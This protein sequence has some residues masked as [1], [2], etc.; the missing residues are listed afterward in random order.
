MT[1]S[2]KTLLIG[3]LVSVSLIVLAYFVEK[4]QQ[5]ELAALVEKCGQ[6]NHSDSPDGPWKQWEKAPLV[7]E[8]SDLILNYNLVG[9]QKDI[10]EQFYSSSNTV[11][12]FK[13][14]AGSVLFLCAIPYLWHFLLRRIRELSNAVK[15]K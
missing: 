10:V 5:S 6:S 14:A 9:I 12:W 13:I 8:P 2:T 11:E 1:K 4:H 3:I 7:C 15:G